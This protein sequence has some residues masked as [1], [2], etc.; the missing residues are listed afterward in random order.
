MWILVGT[1]ECHSCAQASMYLTLK[2]L[3][4][5]KYPNKVEGLT[6]INPD[7][8]QCGWVEWGYQKVSI[9]PHVIVTIFPL[10]LCISVHQSLKVLQS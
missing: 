3:L 10:T 9:I 1:F 4:Q 6:L 8:G 5:L 2:F 7:A